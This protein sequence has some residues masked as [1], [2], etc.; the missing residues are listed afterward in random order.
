[1]KTSAAHL[2]S[3]L[4]HARLIACLLLFALAP[5]LWSQTNTQTS[6]SSGQRADQGFEAQVK[7]PRHASGTGP[8]IAID[9]AHGNYHTAG[10][11]YRPFADVLRADGYRVESFES[12]FTAEKLSSVD[13]LVIANAL[14]ERNQK[15]WSLPTPS[16]F[17]KSEIS[18]I[19]D[20]V[21]N[22]GALMLIADHMPFPGASKE[23]AEAF[24]LSLFNGFV[25]DQDRNGSLRFDSTKNRLTNHRIVTAEDAEPPAASVGWIKNFTGSCFRGTEDWSP[26]F[27]LGDGC[28]SLEPRVAWQFNET[29]A[30]REVAGYWQGAVREF[31]KGRIAMF[32][33]AAMFTAQQ[34]RQARRFGLR[35]PEAQHNQQFLLNTM[36][37][38]A[39][40]VDN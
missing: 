25:F 15:D 10:G 20:W 27:I 28:Y 1:M 24:G 23:L 7:M 30:R 31:G 16:A 3:N 33:E 29:T 39:S 12:E 11:R 32:G 8:R 18:T 17:S 38:L 34:G 26:L 40:P 19:Q 6:E 36:H 14:A 5:S 4:A 37:W 2:A 21:Q 22:G 13:V 35:H 9:G